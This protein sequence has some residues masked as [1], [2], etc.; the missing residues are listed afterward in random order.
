VLR[1]DCP[2]DLEAICLTC[3]A[4]EPAR[5]Y[6]TARELADDLQRFL[7][8]RAVSVRPLSLPQRALRWAKREPRV[9]LATAGAFAALAI[10]LATATWQWREADAQRN[11]AIAAGKA[12]RAERDRAALATEIGAHLFAYHGDDRAAD[13]IQWLQRRLPGDEARQAD[14]LAA[15]AA[16]VKAQPA[17]NDDT[18]DLGNLVQAVITQLGVD[19]RRRMIAALQAGH[20]PDR[21]LYAAILAFSDQAG[22]GWAERVRGSLRAAVAARPDDAFTRYASAIYCPADEPQAC[23]R[24]AVAEALVRMAP[25]NAYHWLLVAMWS[26]D[27]ARQR[28]ALHEATKHA[29][30]DDYLRRQF[31]ASVE[32]IATAAVPVPPLLARSAQVFLPGEDPKTT[33]AMFV[34]MQ[35]PI[36][37]WQDLVRLC[38]P[39]DLRTLDPQVRADCVAVGARLARAENAAIIARMIGVAI[40]RPLAPGSRSAAEALEVRR[41]YKY[42]DAMGH[43][44]TDAQRRRYPL[45]RWFRDNVAEGE[46]AA[47]RHQVEAA[48]IPGDPPAGWQPDDPTALLSARER[49][50]GLMDVLDQAGALV[51]RGDFAG[52]DALLR[53]EETPMRGFAS[54]WQQA[55]FLTLQGRVRTGLRDYAGAEKALL[56]AWKRVED[57]GPG[58]T[59]TRA[60]IDAALALYT[61]WQRAEPGRGHEESLAEWRFRRDQLDV[62]TSAR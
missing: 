46:L 27:P 59:D 14:A 1:R 2:A 24:T 39:A 21:Q 10:G 37:S 26:T 45:G 48:G 54:P 16:S 18:D 42:L 38:V 56:D 32:A 49:L 36:T 55:R 20:D 53:Q 30:Y 7:D 57:G 12:A 13:L 60:C 50:V 17:A 23:D 62:S 19:Y 9:A 22:A 15:F 11:A 5:R 34:A 4:K 52:A 61:A 40:V 29:G 31:D 41:R 51:R 44:L 25:D 3:L 58:S 35:A 47:L 28:E 43:T 8:N 6:A 33:L